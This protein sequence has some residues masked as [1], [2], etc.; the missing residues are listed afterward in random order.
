MKHF[1]APLFLCLVGIFPMTAQPTIQWQKCLGGSS[2]DYANAIDQTNDGGYIVAGY[3]QSN[4]GNVS[5]NHGNYDYWVAKLDD[6]GNIEWQKSLGGSKDDK[7]QSIH[8]TNDGGYIVAGYSESN[9]GDVSGNHG[10]YDYWV[11]KLDHFGNIEWQKS[12]GGT[13][14]DF[15]SSVQI[16]GDDGYIVAGQSQSKDINVPDHHGMVE[17]K[18]AWIVKLDLLG[19]IVWQKSIGGSSNDFA[20]S[21]QTTSDGGYVFAGFSQS[22]DG[23]VSGNQGYDDFWIVK[24]DHGGN[25]EWQKTLGGSDLDQAY[26]VH[27]ANDGGYIVAGNTQ[28]NDGDILGY[29]GNYDAWIVKL[30][31]GGN[32]EW[33]KPLGGNTPEDA[34]DV[35]LTSDGG[36]LMVGSA[37]SNNGDVSGIHGSYDAWVVKLN[38]SGLIEW[39][40]TLGGTAKDVGFAL[41]STTDGAYVMVGNSA[42]NNGDVSG[43]H[44]HFDAWVLKLGSNPPPVEQPCDVK[45]NNCLKYELLSITKDA[46]GRKTYRIRVTNTCTNDLIYTAIQLPDGVVADNPSDNTIYTSPDGRSYVVR[47]PNESPFYS[48]RFKTQGSGIANGQSD[49]FTYTLP[50]QADPTFIHIIARLEQQGFYEAHLNVFDCPIGITPGT[51]NREQFVTQAPEEKSD[52]LRI[53]PNPASDILHI[54]LEDWERQKVNLRILNAQGTMLMQKAISIESERNETLE[55]PENMAGGMYF[56]EIRNESGSVKSVRFILE[57]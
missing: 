33:Q 23:D 45:E 16:T 47:S 21:I 27:A 2:F 14:F 41:T 54:D 4:D 43:N 56:L 39:Q 13:F 48:I 9:D 1:F 44:G 6:T 12:L 22:N 57:R 5:G 42:S 34:Y 31:H 28:S 46:A 29:H 20:N 10:Y 25:M 36:Y 11:V 50:A 8:S 3:S 35:Q 37:T 40:K 19:N 15:A 52:M 49:I 7:A 24:L 17:F 32:M 26:A 18:D 38:Q 53:Y 30:D 55:L 51:A